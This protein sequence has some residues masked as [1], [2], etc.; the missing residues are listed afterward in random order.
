MT[1]RPQF[2]LVWTLAKVFLWTA[3]VAFG[4]IWHEAHSAVKFG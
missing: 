4:L 1:R 3:V 2:R